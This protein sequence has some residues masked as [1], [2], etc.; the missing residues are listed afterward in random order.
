MRRL[1]GHSV[2]A[3]VLTCHRNVLVSH[4]ETRFFRMQGPIFGVR[5][6]A[7]LPIHGTMKHNIHVIHERR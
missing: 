3:E 2:V 1:E 6:Q 7:F 4:P 5:A